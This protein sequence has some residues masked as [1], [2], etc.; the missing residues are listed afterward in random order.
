MQRVV[1]V[2]GG[3][4]GIGRAI[5]RAF[6]TGGDRVT[7]LG[8]RE[9]VLAATATELN[10]AASA[11]GGVAWRAV[12]LTHPAATEA[13]VRAIVAG[14]TAIDVVVNSAGGIDRTDGDA[15]ADVAARFERDFR[16]NVLTAALLTNAALPH[17]RRPGG[18]V[19]NVSSIAAVRGGGDSYAAAKAALHG[20]TF[21][22]AAQLG[23]EGVTVNVVAPG[24]VADTEF[25]GDSMT[26][27]RRQRLVG[28]TLVGRAGEPDDIAAAV[29]YLASPDA[30]YVTGQVLQVNGG[31]VLGR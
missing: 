14:D 13:A 28:Q 15:L 24:F 7:I 25:F 3:G 5:A 11:G 19:I 26:E 12:D 8:R 1:L 17:L 29:R 30:A 2:S 31:A 6:A 27:A 9:D 10:A 21:T 16:T 4:T 20:W 23:P 22:L 18:R